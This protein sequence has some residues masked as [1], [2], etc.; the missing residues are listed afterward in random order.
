MRNLNKAFK[1]TIEILLSIFSLLIF[2]LSIG[3][4]PN[5]KNWSN[6]FLNSE[7]ETVAIFLVILG[8]V[9]S[10]SVMLLVFFT[11]R[12]D[13]SNLNLNNEIRILELTLKKSL[14]NKRLN[15]INQ[16]EGS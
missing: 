16:N 3:R 4:I 11:K 15:E 13:S 14:L 10:I 1:I 8:F 7:W 9:N 6:H 12:E 2:Y 5:L